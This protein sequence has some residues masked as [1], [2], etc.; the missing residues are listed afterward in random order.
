MRFKDSYSV[1]P[2]ANINV[3]TLESTTDLEESFGTS[4]SKADEEKLFEETFT[5]VEETKKKQRQIKRE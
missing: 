2:E 4:G 3:K 1:L 5:N